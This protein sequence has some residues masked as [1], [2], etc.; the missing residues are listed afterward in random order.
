MSTLLGQPI[1]K[2]AKWRC[3]DAFT[4]KE[5]WT[6]SGYSERNMGLIADGYFVNFNEYDGQVYCI[7]K[8]PS[9]LTVTAPDVGIEL[10]R[11]MVIR[12]T[13]TDIAA[14]TQQKEQTARFPNG[15]PVVSDDSM[16]AL[17]GVRVHAEISTYKCN[18]RSGKLE[19]S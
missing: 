17:D 12:G 19:C 11:S 18:W 14:G 1:Y 9:K 2:G 5:I 3:I 10:G 8:G 6:I 15:V 13:A 7:G 16:S 4:G